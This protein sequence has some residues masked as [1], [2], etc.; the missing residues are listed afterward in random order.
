MKK[1][2]LEEL[3][4]RLMAGDFDEPSP[5]VLIEIGN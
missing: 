1:N 3:V 4:K 2:F 5:R